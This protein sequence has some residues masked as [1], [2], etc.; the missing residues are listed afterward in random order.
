MLTHIIMNVF[1]YLGA[2]AILSAGL[3]VWSDVR[4]NY[5]SNPFTK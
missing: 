5:V 1:L 4:N 2:I 3:C